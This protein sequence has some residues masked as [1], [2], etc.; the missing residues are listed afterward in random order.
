MIYLLIQC[1]C[2]QQN[3]LPSQL[4]ISTP[5]MPSLNPLCQAI[6]NSSDLLFFISI[7][8]SIGVNNVRARAFPFA[9]I[10]LYPS[11]MYNSNFFFIHFICHTGN[12]RCISMRYNL[13][14]IKVIDFNIN[15][16]T[17]SQPLPTLTKLI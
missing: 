1:R 2:L 5:T 6:I 7:S 16:R 10:T 11:C 12:W 9:S 8:K 3:C 15:I 13:T 17:L 14:L 4:S